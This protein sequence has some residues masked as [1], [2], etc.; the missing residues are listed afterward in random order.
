MI[1]LGIALTFGFFSYYYE[2]I[3]Y[4]CYAAYGDKTPLTSGYVTVGKDVT[5]RFRISIRFCFYLTLLN[6][7]RVIVNQVGIWLKSAKLY[8]VAIV[9]YGIN[10]MLGLIWFVFT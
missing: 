10:F 5:K 8:Y 9:M 6:F 1:Q 2:D 3:N 7:I 4:K